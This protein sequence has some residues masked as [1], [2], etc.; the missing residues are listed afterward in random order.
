MLN[1]TFQSLLMAK[2]VGMIFVKDA[3]VLYFQ[4]QKAAGTQIQ[5]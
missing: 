2:K 3:S 5:R 1:K 4:M